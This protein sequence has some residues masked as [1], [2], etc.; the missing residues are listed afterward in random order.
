MP[1]DTEDFDVAD[2]TEFIEGEES[3]TPQPP[4]V[5]E[6]GPRAKPPTTLS[7]AKRMA[8]AFKAIVAPVRA[9]LNPDPAPASEVESFKQRIAGPLKALG[10]IVPALPGD[11]HAEVRKNPAVVEA[12]KAMLEVAALH[13]SDAASNWQ[14]IGRDLAVNRSATITALAERPELRDAA[15]LEL[16]KIDAAA[17]SEVEQT[18]KRSIA[19]SARRM[20]PAMRAL[21]IA[22]QV[23]YNQLLVQATK[24]DLISSEVSGTLTTHSHDRVRRAL[25]PEVEAL[26]LEAQAAVRMDSG[27]Y[28]M[29]NGIIR[30]SRARA[31]AKRVIEQAVTLS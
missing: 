22:A 11:L 17:T 14:W 4:L 19:Q 26:E 9:L 7:P 8:A 27:E 12:C 10:E 2:S 30:A 25:W 5:A 13:D 15:L 16:A 29:P 21:A 3:S 20:I 28:Q 6:D 24:H 23:S 18:L 31:F 1:K